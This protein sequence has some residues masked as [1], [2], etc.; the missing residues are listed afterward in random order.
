[1]PF[2]ACASSHAPSAPDRRKVCQLHD[3]EAALLDKMQT[4]PPS[5]LLSIEVVTVMHVLMLPQV[6]RDLSHLGI[7]LYICVA[8]LAKHNGILEGNAEKGWGSK[9]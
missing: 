9:T 3:L 8:L 4:G 2:S 6:C 5:H 7:E 1:M